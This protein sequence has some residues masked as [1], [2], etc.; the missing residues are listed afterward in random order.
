LT[1]PTD[2]QPEL[3]VAIVTGRARGIGAAITTTLARS[4]VHDQEEC[5]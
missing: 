4:G 1:A 5:S 3:R 2:T